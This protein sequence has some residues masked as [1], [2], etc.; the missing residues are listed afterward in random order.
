MRLAISVLALWSVFTHAET[1]NL[2]QLK[3]EQRE[4]VARNIEMYQVL[5][6]RPLVKR[7]EPASQIMLEYINLDNALNGLPPAELGTFPKVFRVNFANV[8]KKLP[9]GMRKILAQRLAG[10]FAVKNLGSTGYTESVFDKDGKVAAAFIVFDADRIKAQANEWA[11]AK[12]ARVFQAGPYQVK[13]NLVADGDKKSKAATV[14]FIVLHE[15]AHVLS[16]FTSHVPAW[17][18]AP[19]P[20]WAKLP[21]LNLSWSSPAYDKQKLPPPSGTKF[22][23]IKATPETPNAKML[24]VY[25]WLATTDFPTLYAATSPQDDFADSFATWVHLKKLNR[26]YT[27]RVFKSGKVVKTYLSCWTT[28][29]CGAKAK[30][31]EILW[32]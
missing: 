3:K 13:V 6:K 14:E 26:P 1:K 21:F 28:P 4:H 15:L 23:F 24:E 9:E 16:L 22:S 32:K 20:E 27:I 25:D 10:V 12:D 11:S 7:D 30:I 8:I 18:T 31:F 19:T 2:E 17:D 5:L 29:R